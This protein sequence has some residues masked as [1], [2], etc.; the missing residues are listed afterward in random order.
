MEKKRKEQ[1]EYEQKEKDRKDREEQRKEREIERKKKAEEDMRGNELAHL[2]KLNEAIDDNSIG[3]NPLFDSIEAVEFLTR[4]C[5]KKV[6]TAE[7]AE[8]QAEE[9]ADETIEKVKSSEL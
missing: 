2:S 3:T 6:K 1:E 7:G 8:A 4:Y 5:Q 9:K